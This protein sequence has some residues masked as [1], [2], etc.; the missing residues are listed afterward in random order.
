M[1]NKQIMVPYKQEQN[2]KELL[3]RADPYHIIS[4]VDDRIHTYVPSK[5]R[6]DSCAHLVVAKSSFG[7]FATER[8]YKFRRS[9]SCLSKNVIY[10]AFCLNC[11]KK[12]VRSTVDWKPRLRNYKF[13]IKK[14]VQSCSIVNHFIDVCRDKDDPS[15]NIRFVI[16]DQLNNTIVPR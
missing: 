11:L 8:T 15:R 14:K 2:L 9:T 16:I 3:T 12:G 5:Q 13:H 4:N 10:I 7:C 1:Q 6:C